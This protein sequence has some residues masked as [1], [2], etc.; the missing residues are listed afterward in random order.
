MKFDLANTKTADA[1]TLDHCLTVIY[2]L[3]QESDDA[4]GKKYLSERRKK[5]REAK[6]YLEKYIEELF[7]QNIYESTSQ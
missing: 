5:W 7:K 4:C 2:G 6:E 3:F 1:E